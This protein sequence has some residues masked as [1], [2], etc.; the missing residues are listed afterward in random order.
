MTDRNVPGAGQQR[1]AKT[2]AREEIRPAWEMD[3]PRSGHELTLPRPP[4]HHSS[5]IPGTQ[6][7]GNRPAGNVADAVAPVPAVV[8]PLDYAHTA[9]SFNYAPSQ[10]A[11]AIL[12]QIVH[13]IPG[14]ST[15]RYEDV[16]AQLDSLVRGT[17]FIWHWVPL[18]RA[19]A[20]V[21]WSAGSKVGDREHGFIDPSRVYEQSGK[22]VPDDAQSQAAQIYSAVKMRGLPFEVYFCVSDFRRAP[23]VQPKSSPK[24]PWIMCRTAGKEGWRAPIVFNQWDDGAMVQTELALARIAAQPAPRTETFVQWLSRFGSR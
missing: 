16:C 23:A 7:H 12:R 4:L 13:S 5:Y 14:I 6:P 21:G 20:D 18:R 8:T 24:D 17:D 15:W 22:W 9:S 2:A 19:D 10:L 3:P 1:Y 11:P